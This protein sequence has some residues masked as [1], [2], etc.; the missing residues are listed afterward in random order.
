MK[1]SLFLALTTLLL[2]MIARGQVI[3]QGSVKGN[4]GQ[5][6]KGANIC[7]RNS[8]DG[9]VS[10]S[11][12]N[13]SFSYVPETVD[14][15]EVS[16]IGYTSFTKVIHADK[17]ENLHIVLQKDKIELDAIVV[18]SAGS[19]LAGGNSKNIVMS[20]LDILTTSTNA[21]VASALQFL[22]GAQQVGEKEGLFVRGGTGEETKQFIDGAIVPNPYYKGAE[23][24]SQRGRFNPYLFSGTAFSTGGYSAVYGNA[25]SSVVLLSSVNMP[26]RSEY[27]FTVSPIMAGAGLQHLSGNKQTSFGASYSVTFLHLYLKLF[28]AN[29]EITQTPVFHTADMNFRQK[30][31]K[32]L[33]KLFLQYATNKTGL[34]ETDADSMYLKDQTLLKNNNLYANIHWN[35]NLGNGWK[36]IWSNSLSVNK[37]DVQGNV[38]D[39]ANKPKTFAHD[40]YWMNS[41]NFTVREDQ[42][43]LHSRAVLEKK[44]TR[45]NG[46]RFG[47]EYSRHWNDMDFNTNTFTL[48]DYYLAGF[49]E[50][51][52]YF[53][54]E[55][56]ITLG[57]R[58][59]YSSVLQRHNMAPRAAATYRFYT[60]NTLS[61]A[62]GIFYQ[63]PAD[64]YLFRN[65]SLNFERACHYILNY[66]RSAHDRLFRAEVYYKNYK[67]LL[68]TIPQQYGSY[69]FNNS[70]TGYARGLDVFWKDKKT[71]PGFEYW[72]S[73]SYLDAKR[74]FLDYAS[75]LQPGFV[76]PHTLSVVAKRFVMPIKT[77]FNITYTFATER[78][79]YFF[80]PEKGGY[81]I[82]DQG[83]TP[84]YH[85]VGFSLNY[86]PFGLNP[87]SNKSLVIV[88]TV[89]NLL[90]AKHVYGYR[91]AHYGSNKLAMGPFNNRFYFLGFFLNIGADRSKQVIDNNL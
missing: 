63:Q 74:Y 71:I 46:L 25:L 68:R 20:T 48:T 39:E 50:M 49:A 43:Y 15:L 44:F 2:S 72:I 79:Y 24:Y 3:L 36:L 35:E 86:I 80:Q 12:G 60:K 31:K 66:T 5:P 18:R 56:A 11:L 65:K 88:L 90:N 34:R 89:S 59:E 85:N 22:P 13:F 1:R 47:G 67:D 26:E 70:G 81:V 55:L 76:T 87:N 62:Y 75:S 83:K 42:Q 16:A 37:D 32:G 10:D 19:F 77:Q 29:P 91:Y 69:T 58:T 84:P 33:V 21:D 6:V 54:S 73:Y 40:M 30:T 28:P 78:P 7:I 61:A 4:K 82:K 64:K 23:N 17:P 41:K 45:L 27:N 38:V 52:H 51:D 9:S 8:Y 57:A 53:S 14:T